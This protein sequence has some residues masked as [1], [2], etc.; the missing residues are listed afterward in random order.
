[1]LAT[2]PPVLVDQAGTPFSF[3]S[4]R[5]AP[6][7]VTFVSAHCQD[8]CP[9]INAQFQRLQRDISR[10]G[11]RAKLI[12]IT[13]DPERDTATDMKKLARTFGAS[14][15]GWRFATGTIGDVHHVMN[16]FNV[17]ATRG[18]D[19]YAEAHSTYVYV[20]DARGR[21]ARTLFA[22]STLPQQIFST[23]LHDWKELNQ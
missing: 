11:I 16:Q 23:L 9:L 14:L 12:T 8:A 21:V 10:V 5:G 22:S 3:S 6:A 13:L 7:I 17:I 20:L 4:L 18:S 15:P 2:T 1:M 19:G